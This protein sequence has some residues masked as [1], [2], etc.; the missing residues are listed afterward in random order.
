MD[1]D[2]K[3]ALAL[4]ILITVLAV[5]AAVAT[6][7]FFSFLFLEVVLLD[8]FK[9]AW[10]PDLSWWQHGVVWFSIVTVASIFKSWGS[11]EE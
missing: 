6:G 11:N 3:I 5:T 8:Y 10:V 9:A 4:T 7:S 1:R 2:D